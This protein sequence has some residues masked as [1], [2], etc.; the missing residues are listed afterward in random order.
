MLHGFPEMQSVLME[1][2]RLYQVPA[3]VQLGSKSIEHVES[4]RGSRG[5]I[6]RGRRDRLSVGGLHYAVSSTRPWRRANGDGVSVR[7]LGIGESVGRYGQRK[8]LISALNQLSV[9]HDT[10]PLM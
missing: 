7:G 3:Q 10:P 9:R 6:R 2:S 1:R 5:G 8:T 4:S